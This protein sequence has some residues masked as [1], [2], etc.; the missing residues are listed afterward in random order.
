MRGVW[1]GGYPA[2]KNKGASLIMMTHAKHELHK[3]M[4]SLPNMHER[5]HIIPNL[6][7][8]KD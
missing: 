2:K 8:G 1:G 6:G 3:Y 4:L 7:R 5:I